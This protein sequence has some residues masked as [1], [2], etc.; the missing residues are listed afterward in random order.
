MPLGDKIKKLKMI[1][2]NT[3]LLYGYKLQFNGRF[4]RKQRA[5]NLWFTKGSLANSAYFTNIDYATYTIT[6]RFSACTIKVW[7][8]KSWDYPKYSVSV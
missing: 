2:N 6:L 1:D 7:L 4:T 5:A 8:Y 3:A